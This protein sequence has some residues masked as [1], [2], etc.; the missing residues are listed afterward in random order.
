MVSSRS[1]ECKGMKIQSVMQEMFK[2]FFTSLFDGDDGAGGV[3]G[4]LGCVLALDGGE[5]GGEAP[6]VGYGEFLFE[7]V[8]AHG[9]IVDEDG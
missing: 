9:E 2:F 5:S 3:G 4:V 1:D 6:G 7:D 8:G